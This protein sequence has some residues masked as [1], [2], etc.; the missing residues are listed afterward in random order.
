MLQKSSATGTSIPPLHM[1]HVAKGTVP[2]DETAASVAFD[3]DKID[4]YITAMEAELEK[5]TDTPI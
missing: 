4:A 2:L 3:H 5:N 1:A